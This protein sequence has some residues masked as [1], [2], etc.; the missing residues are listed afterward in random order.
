MCPNVEKMLS[1]NEHCR[2]IEASN[3]KHCHVKKSHDTVKKYINSTKTNVLSCRVLIQRFL[4]RLPQFSRRA[5]GVRDTFLRN[6][7]S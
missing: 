5:T 4:C 2:G 3:H 7:T 1:T 6:Y